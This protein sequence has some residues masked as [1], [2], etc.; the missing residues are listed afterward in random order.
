MVRN[1]RKKKANSG[2]TAIAVILAVA[3]VAVV[4]VLVY[5]STGTEEDD[6]YEAQMALAL[7]MSA[8]GDYEAAEAA[9][10]M[11]LEFSPDDAEAIIGLADLYITTGSYDKSIRLLNALQ[12]KDASELRSY[13]RLIALY[14]GEAK[15]IAAA[16][17]QISKAFKSGLKP[18]VPGI[19]EAPVISPAGGTFT[20][21]T[22]VSID[23]GGLPVYYSVDGN[24][25]NESGLRYTEPILLRS[26]QPMRL[27]AAVIFDNG[28]LGWPTGADFT[29]DFQLAV[30]ADGIDG[31]GKSAKEIM[32]KQGP[33]F[34]VEPFSGGYTYRDKASQY[35]YVFR[36]D[37]FG[38]GQSPEI[39]PLPSGAECRV[40]VSRIDRLLFSVSFP[41]SVEELMDGLK[42][43]EYA[44][45]PNGKG[46]PH[47][48][49]KLNGLLYD[50]ELKDAETVSGDKKVAVYK[51]N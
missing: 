46:G 22:T 18:D 5:N 35:F 43:E 29:I 11:A 33:L 39:T 42:V 44:V 1:T 28:L 40:V 20:E 24:T 9:Y 19:A 2:L 38:E 30:N 36:S 41:I 25:P 37:I 23:A 13:E 32:D 21:P 8:E 15:D 26:S 14:T 47:L 4:I 10:L 49:Y 16:N 50:F 12:E 17:A 6:T 27:I 3:V 7:E 51:D 31:L 34:Y 45:D 48:M